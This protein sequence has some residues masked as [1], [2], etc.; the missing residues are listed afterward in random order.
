MTRIP[1]PRE[2]P[3]RALIA[4]ARM[5]LHP[6][7]AYWPLSDL[8]GQ[9]FAAAAIATDRVDLLPETLAD[10]AAVWNA[11]DGPFRAVIRQRNPAMAIY[12]EHA[13][14]GDRA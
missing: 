12:C 5:D 8:A 4:L 10:P 1:T 11:L 13:V 7:P 9:G 14:R 6:D 2:Q 3:T